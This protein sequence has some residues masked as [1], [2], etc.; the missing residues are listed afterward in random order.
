MHAVGP[1]VDEVAVRQVPVAEGGVVVLPLL[2]QPG[3]RGRRQPG[4]RAEELLQRG[5]EVAR[6]Q[7]VQV[8]Q[9]QHLRDLRGLAAPRGQDLGRE[10]LA[11]ADGLVD[12][13]VVH[14][15]RFQLHR[16]GGRDHSAGP[17]VAVADHQAVSAF[18]P[19]GGQL[20]YVLVD[21]RLQR[22]SKHPTG[23]LA[24]D[25]VDQGAGLGGTLGIHYAEHGRAFPTRAANAGLLGD[26]TDH[27]GRYALRVSSRGRSTSPEHCSDHIKMGL[28]I[29]RQL[30]GA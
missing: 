18:V 20:G 14:P 9:G 22:C 17:V 21:F 13:A 10:P 28:V 12:A 23:A 29:F 11:L 30:S 15:G 27:S 25:L 1:H 24:H 26:L 4:R 16:P 8:E 7:A 6:G 19:L 2:G 5:H 3:H